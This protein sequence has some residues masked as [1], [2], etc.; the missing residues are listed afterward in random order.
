[1]L[2]KHALCQT[3]LHSD[4]SGGHSRVRTSDTWCFKPVLYRL[5]YVSIKVAGSPGVE[6]RYAVLE[7]AV[8]PLDE[9]PKMDAEEGF[10]PSTFWL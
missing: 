10:E 5:S 3:K 4:E 7:A 8:L 6:P 9:E 1:M 2:P